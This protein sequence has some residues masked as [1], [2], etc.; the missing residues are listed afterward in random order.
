MHHATFMPL[1]HR[2]SAATEDVEHRVVFGEHV[3]LE[4]RHAL[5]AADPNEVRQEKACDPAPLVVLFGR[6][7][8]FGPRPGPCD[9]S[10]M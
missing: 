3:R 6:E 8:Q 1:P 4:L 7:G 10:E 2:Q 9:L 5:F